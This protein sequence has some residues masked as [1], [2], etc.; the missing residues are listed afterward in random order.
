M[1][2][3]LKYLEGVC[4]VTFVMKLTTHFRRKSIIPTVNHGG[5]SVMI[6]GCFAASVSGGN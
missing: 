5:G 4:L 2:Q 6:G 1:R 3:K